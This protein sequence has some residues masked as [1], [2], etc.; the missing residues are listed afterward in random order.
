ML[1]GTTGQIGSELIFSLR[2]KYG[3]ENVVAVGHSRPPSKEI[4]ESG[5]FE[6]ANVLEGK[7]MD[8]LCERYDVGTVYH[9]AAALS[10]TGEK[11][12]QFAWDLNMNGLIGILEIARKRSIRVFWPSSIAVFGNNCPRVNTPQDTVLQPTTMY[13]VT[14]VAGELLCD[15]YHRRYG[16]DVRS[17]RYP[18]VISA[19]TPPGGGT[20][21]YAVAIFYEAV[22]Q[23]HYDCFV[24]K[25][26]VLPMMY[27][28][29]C[30]RAA[31]DLMEAP[32]ERISTRMGYNLNGISFSAGELADIVAKRSPGFH[33]DYKPDFR[34]AIADSWPSSL[35]DSLATK[36]WGWNLEWGLE[37]LADDM[38]A[39]LRKKKE[40]GV[41]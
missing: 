16:V 7:R 9:L 40:Q 41:L 1:I 23:N 38:L 24:R 27:M 28:P 33:I 37:R 36:D 2:E 32:S 20:T 8:E 6:K 3:K 10:G 21:D 39:R 30:L 5:P 35:D 13:G 18:G 11:D 17:V 14:K 34:Q 25:D 29:D 19:E 22:L 12:P 31:I 26:T 4:E 15:Y